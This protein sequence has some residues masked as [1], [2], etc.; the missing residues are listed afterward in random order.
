MPY[1]ISSEFRTVSSIGEY[2]GDHIPWSDLRN[3]S[4]VERFHTENVSYYANKLADEIADDIQEEKDRQEKRK[5]E[6]SPEEVFKSAGNQ[7]TWISYIMEISVHI[8][9]PMDQINA[10]FNGGNITNFSNLN[11]RYMP[12]QMVIIAELSKFKRNLDESVQNL[13]MQHL[14]YVVQLGFNDL[15]QVD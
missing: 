6:Y 2:Y 14:R 9:G 7:G 10:F 8:L 11:S 4:F 12:D 13:Q 5:E 15:D 1:S 3:F